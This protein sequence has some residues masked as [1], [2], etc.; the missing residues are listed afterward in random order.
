MDKLK[1]VVACAALG[2]IIYQVQ[3][4]GG[5]PQRK[6]Y[7]GSNVIAQRQAAAA[8]GTLP[9]D[10]GCSGGSCSAD[11]RTPQQAEVDA[12][13]QQMEEQAELLRKMK[14]KLDAMENQE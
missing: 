13:R 7:T 2:V 12:L 5:N 1:L 3:I 14:E 11:A 6:Y 10:A 8:A 9:A 4:M